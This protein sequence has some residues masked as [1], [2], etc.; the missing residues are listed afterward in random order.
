MAHSFLYRRLR[1]WLPGVALP[2]HTDMKNTCKCGPGSLFYIRARA[3]QPQ[4]YNALGWSRSVSLHPCTLT[5]SMRPALSSGS[6]LDTR[7]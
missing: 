5:S 6:R 4:L 7:P 2:L 3:Q 1:S